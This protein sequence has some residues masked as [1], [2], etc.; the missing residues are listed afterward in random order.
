MSR[1]LSIALLLLAVLVPSAPGFAQ[2]PRDG[3]L[4]ITVVDQTGGVLPG[5]SVTVAGMDSANKAAEIAPLVATEQG[6]ATFSG[7]RPG[8][9]AVKAEFAG[10]D[11]KI[12]PDVRVRAGDNRQ[13]LALTLQKLA[14]EITVGRD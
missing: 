6:I 12:D 4:T 11:P 1:G 10:F 7:L 14:D 5:A 9:Y 13:T 2:S 3:R 8:R